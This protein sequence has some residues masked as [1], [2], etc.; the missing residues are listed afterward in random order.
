M[1]HYGRSAFLSRLVYQT[2]NVVR[3][4]YRNGKLRKEKTIARNVLVAPSNFG[5]KTM[6]NYDA[7]AAQGI[8]EL[9]TLL[10]GVND[11]YRGYSADGYRNDFRFILGKAIE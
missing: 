1:A 6:P 7:L 10:I 3:E 5:E 2:Y 4:N 8:Y 11:Q 9:V